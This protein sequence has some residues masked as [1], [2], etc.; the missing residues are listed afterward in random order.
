MRERKTWWDHSFLPVRVWSIVYGMWI[1]R[2][3]PHHWSLH[4]PRRRSLKQRLSPSPAGD[5]H[6]WPPHWRLDTTSAHTHRYYCIS[7]AI[8]MCLRYVSS[9]HWRLDTTSTDTQ[10]LLHFMC[11]TDV[12]ERRLF[13]SLTPGHNIYRHTQVLL[14]FMC[15]TDVFEIRLFSSLTPGHNIYTHTG[16]SA[17]HVQYRCVWDTSLLLTD[18]WTQHLQTHRHY[19]ISC[20]IQMCLRYVS[21]PHWRLDTTSTHTQVLLHFMCNT[22]VFEIRLFSSLTPGHNIYTHTG[23][24]AFHVQYRCVWD[25]SSPHWRLDTTSTHTQA[26]LHFMCNTDVFEIRLF[27]SL[28]PGHNIYTHTGTSAFHVQYRCVWDTSLLLTDA[29]TQ[30]LHT[31][32]YYCI[33]CAIQMCLRYVSSP[34]K[35][36]ICLIRNCEILLQFTIN[37][38][39]CKI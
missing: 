39:V 15:N 25:T 18:A 20:A 38:S 23:T 27:S 16:T 34:H 21:S 17:F 32:R 33:S 10:V 9:P 14:H 29:W 7:C 26:L 28:T 2:Y 30:H 35:G 11:N 22:D 12:F 4:T 19:C 13:S 37:V 31:H 5:Q 8:Q 24:T 3:T 6:T 1:H 36:C